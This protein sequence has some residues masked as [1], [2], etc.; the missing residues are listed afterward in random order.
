MLLLKKVMRKW[1]IFLNKELREAIY[2][3]SCLTK[4][5]LKSGPETQDP[6]TRNSRTLRPGTLGPWYIRPR[7]SDTWDQRPWNPGPGT[8]WPGTWDP[9]TWDSGTLELGPCN[10]RLPTKN[11]TLGT[12]EMEPWDSETS[13]WPPPEIILI[14]FVKQILTIKSW[15]MYVEN[16]GFRIRKIKFRDIFFSFLCQK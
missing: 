15:D 9:G 6:E 16:V 3:Q 13:N 4:H 1:R 11:L 2:T 10:L 5:S 8:P 7:N 14:S 12:L